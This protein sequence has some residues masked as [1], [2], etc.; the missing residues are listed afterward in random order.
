MLSGPIR[1]NGGMVTEGVR[2][3]R[4]VLVGLGVGVMVGVGVA[5][6]SCVGEAV[7]VG[8]ALGHCVG[9]AVGVGDG[10]RVISVGVG[11]SVGDGV[12]VTGAGVGV[13]V[14]AAGPTRLGR[15]RSES[16]SLRIPV[17]SFCWWIAME[18]ATPA[19]IAT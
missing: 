7:G 18:K 13:S 12:P 17:I 4:G 1:I 8:V 10:V 11:D 14:I 6:S 3:G 9:E 16:R 19:S 2:E 15:A 5:L